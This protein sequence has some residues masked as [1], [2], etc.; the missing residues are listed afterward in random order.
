MST[1]LYSY[2]LIVVNMQC[3]HYEFYSLLLLQ[4]LKFMFIINLRYLLFS[5]SQSLLIIIIGVIGM[6]SFSGLMYNY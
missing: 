5:L 4:K 3:L 1:V 2:T 6:E